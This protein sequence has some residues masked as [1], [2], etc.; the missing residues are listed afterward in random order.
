MKMAYDN[1]DGS[2]RGAF[3]IDGFCTR[4][5]QGRTRVYAMIKSGELRAVK[6]GGKTLILHEDAD[7]WVRNLPELHARAS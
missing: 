4:F 2:P 6:A 1:D 7:K 5:N 3:T